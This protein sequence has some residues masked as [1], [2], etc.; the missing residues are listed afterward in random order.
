MATYIQVKIAEIMVCC[1]MVD[2]SSVRHP[3]HVMFTCI[4]KISNPMFCVK[5]PYLKLPAHF[6]EENDLTLC[7]LVTPYGD[8]ELGQHWLR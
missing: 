4:L 7:G 6:P 3:F 8:M 1:L 5:F 2:L